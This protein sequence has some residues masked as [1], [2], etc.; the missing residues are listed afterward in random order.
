MVN[1]QRKLVALEGLPP[2]PTR[3]LVATPVRLYSEGLK[4]LLDAEPT[5]DV[6]GIALDEAAGISST[7]AL[8]PEIVL[9]DMELPNAARLL[10]TLASGSPPTKVIAL[11]ME[12][13][14]DGLVACIE[15]G[16]AG[17][18]PREG[19]VAELVARIRSAGR[20]EMDCSPRMVG[21]LAEQVAN[22]AVQLAVRKS[23]PHL[24]ARE[25][26]IIRLIEEGLSNKQIAGRLHIELS[27]VKNH[28][29]RIIE[30]LDVTRRGE[31]AAWARRGMVLLEPRD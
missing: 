25:S 30:K 29:H 27:T 6:V 20:G 8:R 19:S 12:E 9:V 11:G 5:I 24:T 10:R 15:A 14:D 18:V 31:V 28:V 4:L 22:L 1:L 26:E 16:A 7:V 2:L 13:S 23:D 21:R 3:L 17:W